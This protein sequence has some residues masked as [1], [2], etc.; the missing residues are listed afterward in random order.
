MFQADP[1]ICTRKPIEPAD[2]MELIK[3]GMNL[4]EHPDEWLMFL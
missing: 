1:A 4:S 3:A 2:R